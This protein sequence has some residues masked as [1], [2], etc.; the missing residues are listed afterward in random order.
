LFNRELQQRKLSKLK[1]KELA[2][3][4]AFL[5]EKAQ[6]MKLYWVYKKMAS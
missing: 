4:F 2:I 5:V 3:Y 1:G 6:A